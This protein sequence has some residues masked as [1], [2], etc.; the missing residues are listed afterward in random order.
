VL[1]DAP[2]SGLGVLRRRPEARWRAQP[3]QLE[4]LAGLQQRLL[5]AAATAVRPGGRLVY[6]VCT[7]SRIET[8]GVDAWAQEHLP[9][10]DAIDPPGAPFRPHGRGAI[11]LPHSVGS[12][13]MFVLVLQ[14]R[15]DAQDG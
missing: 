14:R 12:D 9:D 5:A 1:L 2:C 15:A 11:V 3:E 13:G 10:F 8:L 7:L 6:S 4:Q